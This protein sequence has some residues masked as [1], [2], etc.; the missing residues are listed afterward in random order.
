MKNYVAA[1]NTE[2]KLEPMKKLTSE[3]LETVSI[4]TVLKCFDHAQDIE[5]QYWQK[6]GL[7]AAPQVQP[8]VINTEDSSD[9]YTSY[10][11]SSEDE[12]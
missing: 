6:D 11:S 5:R 9:D 8:V 12:L 2:F 4:Q 7:F 1:N 3:A 10:A